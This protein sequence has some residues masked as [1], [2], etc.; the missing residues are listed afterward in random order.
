MFILVDKESTLRSFNF[1]YIYFFLF[2]V[3]FFS[4]LVP[5]HLRF[6]VI[7]HPRQYVDIELYNR[8]GLLW[9]IREETLTACVFGYC[10]S[11]FSV[12]VIKYHD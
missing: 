6:F 4:G 5:K 9:K 1:S 11:Y 10:V 12:A 3:T 7:I 8:Q 2:A